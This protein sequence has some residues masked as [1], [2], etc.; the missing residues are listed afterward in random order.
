MQLILK[1]F[2]ESISLAW[3]ELRTNKLRAF[4][5]ILGIS[6]GI[7]CII[8]VFTV[9][10]TLEINVKQ[11]VQKLGDN[12]VYVQKW[13]WSFEENYPWWKY[14][15][16]PSPRSFELKILQEKIKTMEAAAIT[17]NFDGAVVQY[18]NNRM[19]DV[20]G[21]S[22]SHDYSKIQ[23]VELESGRYFSVSESQAGSMVA[24]IGKTISDEIFPNGIDPVGKTITV[25]H[26]KKHYK[27]YV[28]GVFKKEG[29]DMMGNSNDEVLMTPYN[30]VRRVVDERRLEP[31]IMVKA[32]EGISADEL[33]DEIRGVMRS[34]RRLKPREE[35]DFALNRLS[36]LAG[37]L[38][39]MFGV[40]N[41]GGWVIGGFA[42][43]VGG[44]G[45]ANIMF[46]SVKERT[47][48]IGIKKALGA[49]N[50]FILLEFLIEAIILC[51]FGGM[52]GLLLV[53]AVVA[54]AKNVFDF[55]L[56]MTI[57]N[58][59][60]GINISVIIGVIAGFWPAFIASRM[61]PVEAIR[62]S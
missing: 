37:P 42:I 59:L 33:Q 22:V 21:N 19:E 43:L 53:Y 20:T 30:S 11:S 18:G 15:N 62:Q 29:D 45:I 14:W 32:K 47:S 56:F 41:V 60:L 38:N 48:I 46:V 52:M 25:I 27:F 36:L 6:I 1:I 50:Y 31:W 13:P 2:T 10:D 39:S 51:L 40:I 54:T 4:L 28:I 8:S 16:R 49:K 58:I 35:D 23:N 34:L 9:T 17:M 26:R 61:D 12:V 44:F 5:S 55:E 3:Q 24:I 7:F 57:G